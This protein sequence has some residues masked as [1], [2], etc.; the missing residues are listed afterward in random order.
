MALP[1]P[2]LDDSFPTLVPAFRALVEGLVRCHE[3]G[4]PFERAPKELRETDVAVRGVWELFERALPWRDLSAE[5][6]RVVADA[7]AAFAGLRT[8]LASLSAA[9]AREEPGPVVRDVAVVAGQLRILQACLAR[10]RETDAERPPLSPVPTVHLLLQAGRAVRQG[11]AP[12]RLLGEC[13]DALQPSWEAVSSGVSL[14]PHVEAHGQALEHLAEI[15]QA[16]DLAGLDDALDRLRITGDSLLEPP[17]PEVASFLCPRCGGSVGEWDR[18]CPSCNARMPERVGEG[19]VSRASWQEEELPDYVQALFAAAEGLR[20][21]QGDWEPYLAAVAELRRRSLLCLGILERVPGAPRGGPQDEWE[22]WQSSQEAIENGLERFFEA[23]DLL[24][25][26]ASN[27]DPQVLDRGL[28][29][30][31]DAVRET[32]QVEV[33]MQRLLES[34]RS[35]RG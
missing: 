32:R 15:V 35:W 30:V 33:F 31:L 25:S 10:L 3:A 6:R 11:R 29:A 20:S 5:D 19:P 22:A 27:P 9:L 7:L 8:S 26:L 21:D 13:L 34:R 24:E 12:W 23:L 2:D 28:E 16:E 4:E 18:N 17:A 1:F 14:P